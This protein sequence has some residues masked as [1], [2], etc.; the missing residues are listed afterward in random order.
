M[1]GGASERGK[2]R[3]LYPDATLASN[4]RSWSW[5]PE[6]GKRKKVPL[7]KKKEEKR[8]PPRKI[9]RMDAV[10]ET[11]ARKMQG[12]G[13]PFGAGSG[14][15]KGQEEKNH[16]RGGDEGLALGDRQTTSSGDA[17]E[18]GEVH[19]NPEKWE[20]L[21]ILPGQ[22]KEAKKGVRGRGK[23]EKEKVNRGI[24]IGRRGFS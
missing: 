8:C 3:S 10:V 22:P 24:Y 19:R 14:A 15:R 17:G 1:G 9:F 6:E 12:L 23:N 16:K 4:Q 20:S 7:S 11:R 2:E 5:K 18:G 21:L 13:I